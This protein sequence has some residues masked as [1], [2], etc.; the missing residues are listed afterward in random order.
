MATRISEHFT[1]EEFYANSYTAK[2]NNIDNTPGITEKNEIIKLITTVLEP[3]RKEY[4]KPIAINCGFRCPKLNTAVG[5]SKTSQHVKG[6][7]ADI[8]A[9]QTTNKELFDLIIN[10]IK[11]GKIKTGQ[12]IWEFG[13]DKEP[14]WIHIST[15][16]SKVNNILRAKTV[17]KNTV[18]TVMNIGAIEEPTVNKNDKFIILLDNGH[19]KETPG[20][21]SPKLEN[22]KQLFEWQWTR[23]VTAKIAKL[24]EQEGIEYKML[25][26]EERDVKLAV[27]CNRANNYNREAM[28]Q[29]KSTVFISVHVNAAGNEGK[30]MN[31]Y[32]WSVWTSKGITKADTFATDMWNEAEKILKEAGQKIRKD[33]SDGDPDYESDFFVL[34]NTNMPAVLTE[35]FFMDC[36]EECKWL[37]TE[38]AK[39]ICAKIHVEGIKKYINR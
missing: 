16:Y 27:R 25:V 7:A 29:G 8:R 17:N 12:V 18:Y 33:S 2:K 5:G 36:K 4:G 13:T 26:P 35:N 24:L 37:M 6:Q 10:M 20:K 15:P 14:A 32:G 19:G 21:R 1:L 11:A 9:T 31:A 23:E 38:E 30:W 28:K 3:I 39:D 34:K 22:G